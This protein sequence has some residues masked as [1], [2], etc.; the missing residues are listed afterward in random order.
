MPQ[1]VRKTVKSE[2]RNGQDCL[3]VISQ[4]KES[5]CSI[6]ADD[7]SDEKECMLVAS[8]VDNTDG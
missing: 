7:S 2:A 1:A 5:V 4:A 6:L 3:A 8:N